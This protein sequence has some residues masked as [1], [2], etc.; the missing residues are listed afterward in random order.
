MSKCSKI[1]RTISFE[2]FVANKK[3]SSFT[4]NSFETRRK[5]D[6]RYE[7][8]Q[9]NHAH[10]N[11]TWRRNTVDHN[12]RLS[13]ITKKALRWSK[14]LPPPHIPQLVACHFHGRVRF[15]VSLSNTSTFNSGFH[16]TQTF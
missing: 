4:N 5:S 1:G 11:Y 2:R 9:T 6:F 16:Q 7:K 8:S 12:Y 10:K 14:T 13:E 3:K 15:L